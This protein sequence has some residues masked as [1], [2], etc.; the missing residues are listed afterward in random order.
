MS[1][2]LSWHARRMEDTERLA[3]PRTGQMKITPYLLV[4]HG[5]DRGKRVPLERFPA[6]IGRADEAD[7]TL[8]DDRISRI[9][10]EVDRQNGGFVVRDK[11]S[12]NGIFLNGQRVEEARFDSDAQLMVG[13]TLLRIE[14]KAD[15]ELE[16]E[17]AMMHA[18]R[19]AAVGTIA[20]GVAHEFNNI[21]AIIMGYL[22]LALTDAALSEAT[23][24]QLGYIYEATERAVEVTRS[25][26]TF[27]QKREMNRERASFSALVEDVLRIV[28]DEYQSEGVV[29]ERRLHEPLDVLV[30]RQQMS[31]AIMHLVINARHAMLGR[32][33]KRLTVETCV[34]GVRACL[35]VIDTGCGIPAAD[36]NRVFLPFVS[37]KGEHAEGDTPQSRI[38]GTGLGLSVCQ[39][40]VQAHG[41]EIGVDSEVGKGT[42]FTLWLPLHTR[43]AFSATAEMEAVSLHQGARV[44]VLDDEPRIRE[45]LRD[46]LSNLGY[47][48]EAGDDGA[49]AL[50][51]LAAEGFDVVL[52]DLQM[53]KMSGV[54]FLRALQEMPATERPVPLV[55]TGKFTNA[56]TEGYAHLGV[57]DTLQKPCSLETM[58]ERIGA[59]LD[60]RRR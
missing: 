6:S 8:N 30:D 41:G 45:V 53:P 35:H 31:Q 42:T 29:I 58:V 1:E 49:Q 11:G 18:E 12:R 32:P 33:E 19:M 34:D 54:D 3:E 55:I 26:L 52:V 13:R 36:R 23:R 17:Q 37:T 9:H 2:K 7:V 27:S 16:M 15:S 40:V 56:N 4:L 57:F 5:H 50:E 38:K 43:T 24:Q 14:F 46:G 21:H 22:E 10:C 60:S 51:R 28:S 25:L 39:T 20:S 44:Y 48:V 59:A 47:L